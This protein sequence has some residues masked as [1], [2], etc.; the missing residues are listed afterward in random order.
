MCGS[1]GAQNQL[2]QS[3]ADFYNEA[4]Q[5][6]EQVYGQDQE[7]LST[8]KSAYAP[9][10]AGGPNQEGFSQGETNNLN[11]QATE[12]TAT[13]Y[14]QASR[15]LREQQA[16]QGAP[17][18]TGEQEQ[19]QAALLASGAANESQ[20][21]LGIKQNSYNQ[22]FS[23]WQNAAAGLTGVAGQL[24]PAGYSGA[25][26]GAG[27]AAADTANQVASENNSWLNAALGAAGAIGTGIISQNPGGIFD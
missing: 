23:E 20:E 12:G 10:L 8:L 5:Q 7:I 21:K 13:D 27:T 25:A 15:A 2:E 16:A 9:I 17:L 24:N 11:T 3:Q 22:G 1:T 14:A 26:T 6:Q 18:P 19:Q 4:T